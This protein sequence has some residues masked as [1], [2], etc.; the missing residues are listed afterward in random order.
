MEKETRCEQTIAFYDKDCF[1]QS[2]CI[3]N[4]DKGVICEF[5]CSCHV[6]VK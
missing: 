2:V 6:L 4:Y 1:S 3:I 5:G